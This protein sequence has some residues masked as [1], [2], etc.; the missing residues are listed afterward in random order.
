MSAARSTDERHRETA[1]KSSRCWAP[2]IR[3]NPNPISVSTRT[4]SAASTEPSPTPNVSGAIGEGAGSGDECNSVDA[5]H[6]A[7]VGNSGDEGDEGA[8]WASCRA[9]PSSSN[10]RSSSFG[11]VMSW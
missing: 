7:H 2:A 1:S 4:T 9:S 11:M 8:P 6:D 3:C 10:A 5:R